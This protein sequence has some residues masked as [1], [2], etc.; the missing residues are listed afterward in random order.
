MKDIL[1]VASPTNGKEF[2]VC[3]TMRSVVS[4]EGGDV[5]YPVD[6]AFLLT[7][8]KS[9]EIAARLIDIASRKKLPVA[10]FEIES[11]LLFPSQENAKT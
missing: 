8:P 4:E 7:G 5:K 6:T 3:N 11:V 10:A 1:I 9:F 2:E